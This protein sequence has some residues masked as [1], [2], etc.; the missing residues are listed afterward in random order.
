M[1]RAR[2]VEILKT[3]TEITE[4]QLAKARRQTRS[5]GATALGRAL[6]DLGMITQET[7]VDVLGEQL[8]IERIELKEENIEPQI[9]NLLP[10]ELLRQY[11]VFPF[12]LDTDQI[13]IAMYPP[14]NLTVIDEIELTTGYRVR[15]HFATEREISLAINHFF[16]TTNRTKQTIIDMHVEDHIPLKSGELV[17]DD[18][19]DTVDNPPV[20]RLVVDIIEGAINERA[21]D[22]HLEPQESQLRVRYRVDGVLRDVMQIPRHIEASIVS[23][24]KILANMD[25]TEKRAPQDGHMAIRKA[26]REYDIR[27]ATYLTINGEKVV[28]R[29]LSKDTMLIDIERLGF[30]SHDLRIVKELIEKPYGMVLVTGPTGCG[31]TTTLYSVLNRLNKTAANIVTIEDPVEYKLPGINQSQVNT[32]TGATFATGLRS[33]LRQDPNIIMIGEIR[34]S[35]TSMIATQSSLTGHLVFST[36][37]TSNAPG[38]IS[39]LQEMGIKEYLISA[40]V[41]GV[42]AQRLVRVICPYCKEPHKMDVQELFKEFGVRSEKTGKVV[43]YKGAG[44]K[45]CGFTGYHGRIGIF[46]VMAVTGTVQQMILRGENASHIRHAAVEEGM[47]TLRHSAFRK[48]VEGVTTIEEVRRAVFINID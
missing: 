36:L 13:S 17:I 40:S 24:V 5:T 19:V 44:C 6:I 26:G 10:E 38:A 37:H 12:K 25:I 29:L 34:D 15:I 22:I 11:N 28:M 39:R 43:I 42:I 3:K 9:P 18:I 20:V 33:I 2:F 41:I 47:S 31:K 32:A 27:V 48:V 7:Y 35:E 23:R 46:E 14:T 16:S 21:S 45:Y 4:E 30:N 8:G 1:G